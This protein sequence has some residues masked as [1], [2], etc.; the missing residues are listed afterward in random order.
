M[1]CDWCEKYNL[2]AKLVKY[3][4]GIIIL[5][6]LLWDAYKSALNG[7]SETIIICKSCLS[8]HVLE[9]MTAGILWFT[10]LIVIMMVIF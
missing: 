8:Y 6:V 5:P 9:Y 4:I 10:A 1:N 2:V 3:I 7:D